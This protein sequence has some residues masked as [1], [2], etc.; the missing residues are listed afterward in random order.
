MVDRVLGVGLGGKGRYE[1]HWISL[2]RGLQKLN[3]DGSFRDRK[4]GA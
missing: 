3:V 4:G 2:E 1:T